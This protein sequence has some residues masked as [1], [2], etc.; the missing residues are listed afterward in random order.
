M[1]LPADTQNNVGSS[2][3][4][5]KL[6]PNVTSTQGRSLRW[7]CFLDFHH[8][9]ALQ[10]LQSSFPEHAERPFCSLQTWD[11]RITRISVILDPAL[12]M[13]GQSE[14]KIKIADITSQTIQV[15]EQLTLFNWKQPWSITICNLCMTH[16]SKSWSCSPKSLPSERQPS[17]QTPSP[18]F[19]RHLNGCW[20]WPT[21]HSNP[22]CQKVNASLLSRKANNSVWRLFVWLSLIRQF[23]GV[24]FL[25]LMQFFF[26][27]CFCFGWCTLGLLNVSVTHWTF[28]SIK[29]SLTWESDLMFSYIEESLP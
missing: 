17:T 21:P 6:F 5:S 20:S 13:I 28:V 16:V 4:W 7:H 22:Q 8:W 11:H 9:R 3:P 27:S 15:H 1:C 14:T 23:S 12:K 10:Q 26:G 2:P 29:E 25:L 18:A 24:F 19:T